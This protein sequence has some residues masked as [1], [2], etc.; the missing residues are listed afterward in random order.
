MR[1]LLVLLVC[2]G[3]LGCPKKESPPTAPAPAEQLALPPSLKTPAAVP[4][5]PDAEVEVVGT[6]STKVKAA[7]TIAVAQA[8]PCLPVPERP[9]RFGGEQALGEPGPLFAEFFLPQGTTAWV[10][11]YGLDEAGVVVGAVAVPGTPQTFG[12]IGELM[13]GPHTVELTP[14]PPAR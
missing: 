7:R 3:A 6:W 2:G 1:R 8:E 5:L 14:V 11:L 4:P 9:T 12:G 13:V 10:C